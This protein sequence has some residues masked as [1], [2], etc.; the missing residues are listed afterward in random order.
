[1]SSATG[2]PSKAKK[3]LRKS[4]TGS[5]LVLV[6]AGLLVWTGRSEN[7]EPIL[8][9]ATALL[10]GAAWEASRMGTLAL[11]DLFPPL[12]L[13]SAAA[14]M[15]LSAAMYGPRLAGLGEGG[16]PYH[17][18]VWIEAIACAAVAASAHSIARVLPAGRGGS[19]GITRLLVY[20]WVGGAIL[21]AVKDPLAIQANLTKPLLLLAAPIAVFLL[22]SAR[23]PQAL[24]GLA[25]AAALA[26]WIV[27]PLPGLWHIWKSW[28]S[29]GLV[30]FLLCAKVGDTAAYYVGTAF[31]RHHPFPKISPGKTLEGCLG[32]FAAG[33]A[34]GGICAATGL[35]PAGIPAGL[36]A[37]AIVNLAAQ[38]GDLVESWVKRKAGVKDS[39][40]V[41]GPSGGLLD[42]LD[43]ILLAV[44]VALLAWP[45]LLGAPA[46]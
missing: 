12:V 11:R 18:N 23:N 21:L 35:L 9:A 26:A 25:I 16:T 41:F 31:G 15:L 27:P 30:A 44:P 43:S 5:A 6:V 46:H 4:L 29:S 8:Y 7:G 28:S 13:A 38:A 10:L 24:R 20:A 36:A 1:M 42:Q 14:V 39:S 32:S 33:A 3:V 40:S 22:V 2:T 19:R 17:A 34:A 37:G 45:W